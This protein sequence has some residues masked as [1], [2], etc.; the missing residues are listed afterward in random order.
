MFADQGLVSGTNFLM[1]IVLTRKIGIESFG[2]FSIIWMTN[3][4]L[5]SF[6]QSFISQTIYSQYA[7]KMNKP[8]YLGQQKIIALFVASLSMLVAFVV[9][10]IVFQSERIELAVGGSL[11]IFLYQIQ[12][13]DRRIGFVS[14]S[15][16]KVFFRDAVA[17]GLQVP[18][19][20]LLSYQD[21]LTI[22]SAVYV[23]VLTY[24]LSVL[25]GMARYPVRIAEIKRK[26]IWKLAKQNWAFSK[27]LVGTSFLQWFSG[28]AF[29]L[30]AG[31]WLGVSAL[32]VVRMMQNLMGVLH[33]L[34]LALE[35]I[36]PIS[37]AK[38][39]SVGGLKLLKKETRILSLK[40]LI[41]VS[42]IILFF[43][44]ADQE[45]LSWV[46]GQEMIS[47]GTLFSAFA[48]MYFLVYAGTILRFYIRTIE[49]NRLIFHSY[50]ISSAV[51]LLLAYPLIHELGLAGVIIG[52]YSTQVIGLT[53]FLG[54]L[55]LHKR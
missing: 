4:V 6:Q 51:S 40:A 24:G 5:F 27:Y 2:E 39:M 47:Y 35:N 38:Q 50:A 9:F 12:D 1:A 34:F 43:V 46:Y 45:V 44:F 37:M 21:V 7:E 10:L 42:T 26:R 30:M 28:N 29:G 18:L 16:I 48:I 15:E 33:V 53:Y 14:K 52:F 32:G 20:L 11:F 3:F 8:F 31:L 55:K 25:M 17:Y 49:Q 41:P 13:F 36:V 23:L 19:I 54:K 22:T